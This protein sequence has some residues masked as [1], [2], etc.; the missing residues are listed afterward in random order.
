MKNYIL[1]V[2]TATALTA[3]SC[4]MIKYNKVY[5]Y[6]DEF[7]DNTKKYVRIIIKPEERRL[8]IGTAKV[9]LAKTFSRDHEEVNGYFVISRL[10]S[11]FKVDGSG[12]M[13]AGGRRYELTLQNPVS[14][15]RSESETNVPDFTTSDSTGVRTAFSTDI[16]TRTWIEDKFVISMP[17]EVISGISEAEDVLFRFYFGP[18]PV[19]YRLMGRKLEAV[20]EV[21]KE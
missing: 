4:G 3:V 1:L 16:D 9:V 15:L 2:T 19:T 14:E 20:K 13:K 5:S 7:R 12:F 6:E 17:P 18:I 8:E 11:S 10:S 21:F